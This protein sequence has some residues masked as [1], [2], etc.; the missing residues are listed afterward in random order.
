MVDILLIGFSYLIAGVLM[1]LVF[2]LVEESHA[3]VEKR[4]PINMILRV[5]WLWPFFTLVYVL[6]FFILKEKEPGHGV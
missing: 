1:G 5:M 4:L 3:L 6:A 2:Q